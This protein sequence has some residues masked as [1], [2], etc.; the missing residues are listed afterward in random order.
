MRSA[1]G[2]I[3]ST[4]PF[5][6]LAAQ[7]SPPPNCS[8]VAVSGSAKRC[9]T[10][11]LRAS[12]RTTS[13]PRASQTEPAPAA[14]PLGSDERTPRAG[15][16]HRAVTFP[17]DVDTRTTPGPPPCSVAYSARSPS[18][19]PPAGNGSFTRRS[20]AGRS[21]RTCTTRCCAGRRAHADRRSNTTSLGCS[22]SATRASTVRVRASMSARPV[23]PTASRCTGAASSPLEI[24]TTAIAAAAAATAQPM[25]SRPGRARRARSPASAPR[26]GSTSAPQL[27]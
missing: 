20:T 13:A 5:W 24:T 18:A 7:R 8:S 4:S 17:V 19:I 10:R 11:P 9:C 3:F 25:A 21:R 16:V 15:T 23:P 1:T 6:L 14:I 26:A 12:M 27:G 2:S 22:G